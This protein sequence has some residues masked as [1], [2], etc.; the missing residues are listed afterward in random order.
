MGVGHLV[1]DE[2]LAA[3]DVQLG[4]AHVVEVAVRRLQAVDEQ[5]PRRL[6][7]VP[8]V[9]RPQP[10]AGAP[11]LDFADRLVQKASM[12]DQRYSRTYP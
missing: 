2:V 8:G 11:S 9:V 4:V 5:V 7:A 3:L 10:A 6:V 12:F 1:L